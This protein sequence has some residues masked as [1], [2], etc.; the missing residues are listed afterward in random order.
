MAK[1]VIIIAQQNFNDKEFSITKSVLEESEIDIDIASI[2]RQECVGMYG[3]KVSPNKTVG[4]IVT[5]YYD[6]LI[7]IG[8]S[9]SLELLKYPEVVNRIKSFASQNKLIAA[10]CLAPMILAKAGILKGIMSTV[11]PTDFAI[12]ALKQGGAHYTDK[13]VVVDGNIITADGPDSA[14]GFAK[15]ILKKLKE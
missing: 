15:E 10:I 12:S 6:A 1:V 7:I 14:L 8:G 5:E 4:D 2:T 9:G 11:F 13:H 3:L